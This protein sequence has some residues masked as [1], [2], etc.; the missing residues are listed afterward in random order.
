MGITQIIESTFVFWI[1]LPLQ[2]AV[3]T[4]L[5]FCL[6]MLMASGLLIRD[7][8][9]KEISNGA[10]H[11]GDPNCG[12]KGFVHCNKAPANPYERGC[13]NNDKC[14]HGKGRKLLSYSHFQRVFE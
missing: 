4:A 14:R 1:F 10:I 3:P 7:T 12:T 9:A 11:E 5:T 6:C 13:E 2:M 8:D